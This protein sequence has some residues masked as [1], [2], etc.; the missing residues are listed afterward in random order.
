[1]SLKFLADI[2]QPLHHGG[3]V[4]LSV[5]NIMT[6]CSQALL[7]F[8]GRRRNALREEIIE[9]LET[10]FDLD[11]MIHEFVQNGGWRGGRFGTRPN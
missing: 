2:F 5:V 7:C 11:Y 3:V 8:V 4:E 10:D 1:M 6:H 9:V